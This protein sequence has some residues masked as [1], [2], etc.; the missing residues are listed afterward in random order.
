M[1]PDADPIQDLPD[2]THQRLVK[3]LLPNVSTERMHRVLEHMTGYYTRYFGS[4]T[5]ERSA[6]WLHDQIADVSPGPNMC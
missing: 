5:G 2:L 4:I 6:V 1:K 3:P